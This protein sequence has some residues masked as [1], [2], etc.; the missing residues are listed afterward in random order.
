MENAHEKI[1]CIVCGSDRANFY[2]SKKGY[3]VVKCARCGT[4]FLDPLPKPQEAAAVYG[5][6]YFGGAE[7]GHGY[8]DYDTDKEAMRSIFI[9]H[10]IHFEKLLK[11]P[12]KML[13]VG[14]ATGFFMKIA[15]SRGWEVCGVEISSFAA[16]AGRKNGLDII[17][18]TLQNIKQADDSFDLVTMWDVIEHMPDPVRD[19]HRVHSLLKPGGLVA[20]N[21][22]DSG[23]FYSHVMGSRWHL[24]VPPE[25]I[26]YFNRKSI[27]K[28]LQNS[29]FE[30]IEIGC[31]GKKFTV[32]YVINFLYRWQKLGIWKKLSA[33]IENTW[34]GK[35]YFPINLRDN[36]YVLARKK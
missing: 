1:N 19:L 16:E 29:G 17:T 3:K 2:A 13:D 26:F 11:R 12:G 33:L 15:K 31:I 18:G 35:L 30:V 10:L 36:M 6:D 32:E 7:K 20:V 28:L 23:S 4:L 24:F 9:R 8:V 14:A 22:P 27:S 25:H 21:T 5:Q 34:L